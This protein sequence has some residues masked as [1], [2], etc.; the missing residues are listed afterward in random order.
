METW[1]K[2]HFARVSRKSSSFLCQLNVYWDMKKKPEVETNQFF[3]KSNK[4]T[5]LDYLEKSIIT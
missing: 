4:R 1:T 5:L 2:P 3:G